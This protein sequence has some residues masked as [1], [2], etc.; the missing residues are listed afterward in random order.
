MKMEVLST[1]ILV[2]YL[3]IVQVTT[4]LLTYSLTHSLTH[5]LTNLLISSLGFNLNFE[6]APF[7]LTREYVDLLGGL[8]SDGFKKFE[9]LFLK[10]FYAL[11]KHL[12]GII[13]IVQLFYGDKRKGAADGV[14]ARL[15][16]ASSPTDVLSL[17]R[18]SL[19]NWRTKQYDWLQ[20]AQN[21][22]AS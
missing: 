14:R 15:S 7:K 19:D 6:N 4:H 20:Q 10:G 8:D 1:L 18:D 5:S 11:R 16:F 9:D 12:A 21:N 2:L 17:I 3:E 22:I 13:A